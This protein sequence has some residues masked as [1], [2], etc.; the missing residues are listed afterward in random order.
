MSG[1]TWKPETSLRWRL[2]FVQGHPEK[3]VTRVL[4]QIWVCIETRRTEWRAVSEE[5]TAGEIVTN[6]FDNCIER[7]RLRELLAHARD[8]GEVQNCEGCGQWFRL[9]ETHSMEEGG[10]IC[11]GCAGSGGSVIAPGE[12]DG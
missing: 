5:T 9:E 6:C 4:E 8:G 7:N 10:W 1:E 3:L 11:K 2:E 12:A